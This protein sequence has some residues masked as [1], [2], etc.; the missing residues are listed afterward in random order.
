[1]KVALIHDWLTGLRGGERC[2]QHFLKLY[3]QADV[4]TLL[5]VAGSTS[6]EI[7]AR[8]KQTSFLQRL[9]HVGKYYRLLFPLYPSAANSLNVDGYDLVVSLSHAAAKNVRLSEGTRHVCYCFTPMRYIWDQANHYFGP[10]TKFLWP[11]ILRMRRWDCEASN[12]VSNFVAISRFVAARIR[13]Y[14]HRQSDVIYPP[15]DTSWI[16]PAPENQR[17]RAFL[18]AGALAP[19]KK[20]GLVIEAFN[21]TGLELWVVGSGQEEARLRRMAKKNISFF[22][23]VGDRDLSDLYRRCR[24]LIFPGTEDFGMV[25]IECQAAGRPVIARYAGALRESI[26]GVKCWENCNIA[27]NGYSGVFF[28]DVRSNEV[29]ALISALQFFVRYEDRFTVEACVAQ[30]ATFSPQRFYE[31]WAVVAQQCGFDAGLVPVDEGLNAQA[32][33]AVI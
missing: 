3:P 10:A 25:P 27:S 13:A 21:R 31:S 22:G 2:L 5:H 4:Y 32:E 14:Y 17:G 30:A 1:M 19:Y 24:A 9:P 18:Y 26:G 7:D 28:P 23:R 15:V 11:Q 12:R 29:E 20:P 6:V 8:V 33:A 16:R